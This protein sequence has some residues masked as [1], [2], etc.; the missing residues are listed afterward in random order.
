MHEASLN[1]GGW[2]YVSVDSDCKRS[3]V[4]DVHLTCCKDLCAT[5]AVPQV[6]NIQ[7]L[8]TQVLLVFF[9]VLKKGLQCVD[10]AKN[11]L[12]LHTAAGYKIHESPGAFSG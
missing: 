7:V 8:A 1:L 12:R 3:G 5:Y 9:R 2:S 10:R 6:L 11:G 4:V